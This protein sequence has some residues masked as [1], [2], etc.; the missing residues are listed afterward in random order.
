MKK[1]HNV[2]NVVPKN[3]S[4]IVSRPIVMPKKPSAIKRHCHKVK[5]YISLLFKF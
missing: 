1:K 2:D 5:G 4:D 3:S